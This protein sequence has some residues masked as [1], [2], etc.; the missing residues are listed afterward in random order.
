MNEIICFL[1]HFGFGGGGGSFG[2]KLFL[3]RPFQDLQ[4]RQSNILLLL[5]FCPVNIN[6][7]QSSNPTFEAVKYTTLYSDSDYW[8]VFADFSFALIW[9][10]S[11]VYLPSARGSDS[12]WE[13]EKFHSP[14]PRA[15][16]LLLSSSVMLAAA[17]RSL[18]FLRPGVGYKEEYRCG[19]QERRAEVAPFSGGLLTEIG[20]SLNRSAPVSAGPGSDSAS[21][22]SRISSKNTKTHKQKTL[23][24]LLFH[25][26]PSSTP[27]CCKETWAEIVKDVV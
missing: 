3:R 2:N 1:F 25:A 14:P 16:S 4:T 18:S 26:I 8:L 5:L 17:L 15:A 12:S 9:R 22:S 21:H 10:I 23:L 19:S 13:V 20:C 6:Q 24:A 11:S 27:A 7:W